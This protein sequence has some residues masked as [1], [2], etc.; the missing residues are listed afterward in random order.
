LKRD[1]HAPVASVELAAGEPHS[2]A[3]GQIDVPERMPGFAVDN[4]GLQQESC[5]GKRSADLLSRPVL[6]PAEQ[7]NEAVT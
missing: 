3:A 2:A 7:K 6:P 1:E 4:Q 5:I